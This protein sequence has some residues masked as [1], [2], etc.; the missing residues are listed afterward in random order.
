MDLVKVLGGLALGAT[1]AALFD[2][3]RGSKKLP[4]MG[5]GVVSGGFGGGVGGGGFGGGPGVV[6]GVAGGFGGGGPS[7]PGGGGPGL[8]VGPPPGG[9]AFTGGPGVVDF[10]P[11]G[12]GE[13]ATG[14]IVSVPPE[15]VGPGLP[16]GSFVGINAAPWFWPLNVNW[17]FPQPPRSL[18]CVKTK[19]EDG[20][21]VVF[22]QESYAAQPLIGQRPGQ[23]A[24]GPP[25]GWL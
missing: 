19:N 12:S 25:A 6:S 17:L 11:E 2:A 7:G 1:G 16:G 14:P 20:N 3:L 23:Y 5:Q 18:V 13:G 4:L 24:W 8:V 9:G 15:V 10:A 22:C 21:E